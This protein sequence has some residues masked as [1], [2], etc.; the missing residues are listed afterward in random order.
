MTPDVVWRSGDAKIL[1]PPKPCGLT[2]EPP[3]YIECLELRGFVAGLGLGDLSE[4]A[5]VVFL[6]DEGLDGG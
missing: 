3:L 4:V 2:K 1:I 6:G 5:L